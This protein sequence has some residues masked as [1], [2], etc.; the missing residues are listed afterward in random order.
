VDQLKLQK[1]GDFMV[2]VELEIGRECCFLYCNDG[3]KRESCWCADKYE[4][5]TLGGFDSVAVV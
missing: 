5:N 1:N 3:E 2:V 4:P